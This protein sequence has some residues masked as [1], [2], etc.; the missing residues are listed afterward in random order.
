MTKSKYP[1][2]ELPDGSAFFVPTLTPDKTRY[3][4]LV[5]AM[6]CGVRGEAQVGIYDRKYGVLFRKLET[7]K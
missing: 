6:R 3:E 5:A 4:G 7:L 2:T 1:W